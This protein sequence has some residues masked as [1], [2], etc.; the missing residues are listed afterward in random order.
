MAT[1]D[2]HTHAFPDKLARRAI[3]SLEQDCPW[4]AVGRGTVRSLVRSMDKA[5]VDISVTCA[6]A[7]KPDQA[8]GILD[9]CIEIRSTRIEPLASIHPDTPDPGGWLERIAETGL[10]GIK[11]HPQYQSFA[12]DE[13]RLTPIYD[14]AQQ[15]GLVVAIHCG[16]D[17]AF[18][19]DDDRAAPPRLANVIARFPG[20]KLICTHMGG[21][22]MWDDV[23]R[24]LLGQ[25]VWLETSFSLG[26][27]G[28]DRALAMI[29]K[30]GYR[31]VMLGSDWPW[32]RQSDAIAQLAE[33]QLAPKQF[34]AIMF[35][36]AARLMGI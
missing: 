7:T 3:K 19:P 20:L 17:I 23:E 31:R 12:A 14:A 5:D 10:A 32:N 28:A 2:I 4:K 35:S 36:N 25:D 34:D 11:L 8:R 15:L 24:L 18:P 26:E 29:E 1:I 21:W 22:R 27:L 6:I 9:W 13:E 33:L 16:R 30:H